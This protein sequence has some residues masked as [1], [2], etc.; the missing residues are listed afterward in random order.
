MPRLPKKT[1]RREDNEEIALIDLG[2]AF[3]QPEAS[4]SRG[5]FERRGGSK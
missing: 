1:R 3:T 4:P 2:K 5:F